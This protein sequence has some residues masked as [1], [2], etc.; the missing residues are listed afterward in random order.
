MVSITRGKMS[1]L[2]AFVTICSSGTWF[3]VLGP[4]AGAWTNV[5]F[6]QIVFLSWQCP[7]WI[8]LLES[9][10]QPAG[11]DPAEFLLTRWFPRL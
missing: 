11:E 4:E 5:V 6:H 10:S 8:Q 1:V 2:A 7:H 3:F 9:P